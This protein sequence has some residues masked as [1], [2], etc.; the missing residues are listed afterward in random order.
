MSIYNDLLLPI[1]HNIVLTVASIIVHHTAASTFIHQSQSSTI[2]HCTAASKFVHQPLNLQLLCFAHDFGKQD[3][4]TQF[5]AGSKT[6]I[7]QSILHGFASYFL[8]T[9]AN[10]L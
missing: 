7:T 6:D 4:S 5:E 2:I 3:K 10:V 9:N 1:I 8:C